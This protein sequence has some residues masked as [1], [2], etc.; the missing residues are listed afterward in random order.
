MSDYLGLLWMGLSSS[1]LYA[2]IGL[3]VG[4]AVLLLLKKR[5]YLERAYT[6]LKL[7]T[8]LYF[9]YIPIVFFFTFWFMGSLWTTTKLFEK[10]VTEVIVEIENKTF[11]IFTNYI[12]ESIEEFLAKESIPT[13]KEIVSNFL[14]NY[15]D[16]NTSSMYQYSMQICLTTMLE[17]MI[18]KDSE[19]EKRIRILSEG[20]STSLFKVGF[21][22]LKE[23][24]KRRV[25]QLLVLLLI[26]IIIGFFGAMSFPTL[27]IFIYNKFLRDV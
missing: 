19:R 11:P 2:F 5:H 16:K 20:V 22:Y 9:V 24:V 6:F 7:L 17:Y 26:P 21:T 27:E 23:E 8:R 25:M 14:A 13:N 3:L 15:I 10:E 1:I 4:I 12:N 18:G